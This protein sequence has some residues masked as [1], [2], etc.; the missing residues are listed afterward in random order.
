MP[1][2][3]IT[4]AGAASHRIELMRAGKR[5]ASEPGVSSGAN[6][7]YEHHQK[8]ADV[9]EHGI[10][11]D[12]VIAASASMSPQNSP[13]RSTLRSRRW[14]RPTQPTGQGARHP[15]GRGRR[16]GLGARQQRYPERAAA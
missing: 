14:P 6:W 2:T 12:R 10:S 13:T 5:S 15:R 4:L 16:R 3:P 7:Y 9:A 11:K 1:N 8:M